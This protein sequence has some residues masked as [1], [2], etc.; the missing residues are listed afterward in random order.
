MSVL[1][2]LWPIAAVVFLWWGGTAAILW[3]DGRAPRTFGRSMA[4]ATVVAGVALVACWWTAEVLTPGNAFLAFVAG[5]ILWGWNEMAFLMGF[6]SGPNRDPCPP[7]L[8]GIA[9]FVAA[10]R[11]LL[12]HELMI[13]LTALVL[14]AVVSGAENQTAFHTFLILWVMRL[15][16]KINIHLGAPNITTAFL[17]DH[18]AYLATYFRNRPM[19]LFFPVSITFGTLAAVA[20][21]KGAVDAPAGSGAEVAAL[22]LTTLMALALLEHWMMFLP[23]PADLPWRWSLKLRASGSSTV[24]NDPREPQLARQTITKLG[25][26]RHGH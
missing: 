8:K 19:N 12:H 3:L 14:W 13:A 2:A 6:A 24:E 9:R 15:S 18:L 25:R 23:L 1:S 26:E 20:L 10:S 21:A 22:L 11:T 7:G 5:I 16:A 17:P 4:I